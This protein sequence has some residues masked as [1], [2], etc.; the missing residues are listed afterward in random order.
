[1]IRLIKSISALSSSAARLVKYN[2]KAQA[3][4]IVLA[5]LALGALVITPFLNHAGVNLKSSANYTTLMQANNSCEAGIEEAIWALNYTNL[6]SQLS[7]IGDS[8]SY[9]LNETVNQ[10]N[11]DVSVTLLNSEGGTPHGNNGGSSG[12]NGTVNTY[13]ITSRAGTTSIT[14]TVSIVDNLASVLAWNIGR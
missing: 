7:H 9:R 6:S 2:G 3:L 12:K 13:E 1:M 5:M 8:L 4:P 14:A 11:T 10:L